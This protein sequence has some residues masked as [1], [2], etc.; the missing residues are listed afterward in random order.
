MTIEE[1]LRMPDVEILRSGIALKLILR[2]YR[3]LTGLTPCY[4]DSQLAE[5]LR[6]VR[7]KNKS[8]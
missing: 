5:F 4:C 1:V 2:E 3:R 7:L 8:K 6:V